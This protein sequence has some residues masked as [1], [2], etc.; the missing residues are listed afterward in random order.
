MIIIR[1]NLS[2]YGQI[3][4]WIWEAE[5]MTV[6]SIIREKGRNVVTSLPTAT[7]HEIVKRLAE[8][9][10]GAL[11]VVGEHGD[12][13]GI[14]SERDIVRLIAQQGADVLDDPVSAHMTKNVRTCSAC[15]SIDWVMNE[16]TKRRGRHLPVVEEGRLAGIVSIGDV[17]KQR[18]AECRF[19]A[20]AMREYIATA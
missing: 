18:L 9:N 4:D 2:A 3:W 16:M 10:I 5:Q 15:D 6:A 12:I 14:I 19:E 20:Q 17:V 7:L 11:V 8:N 13:S 1:D